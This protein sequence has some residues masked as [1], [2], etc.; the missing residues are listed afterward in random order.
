MRV[1]LTQPTQL[2]IIIDDFIGRLGRRVWLEHGY[3]VGHVNVTWWPF[4]IISCSNS[5][6]VHL[7]SGTCVNNVN[8]FNCVCQAGFNGTR[9]ENNIN[10]CLLNSCGNGEIWVFGRIS[11]LIKNFGFVYCKRQFFIPVDGLFSSLIYLHKISIFQV[12]FVQKIHYWRFC[13]CS[14]LNL[15]NCPQM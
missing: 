1:V 15:V 6:Y 8:G 12:R 4:F 5:V 13:I 3:L 7:F 11:K 10:E 14:F 2:F 9:C